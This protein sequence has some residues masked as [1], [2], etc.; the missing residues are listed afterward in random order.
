MC[1]TVL[2][3]QIL[4][5]IFFYAEHRYTKQTFFLLLSNGIFYSLFIQID[6]VCTCVCL[7]VSACNKTFIIPN[8]SAKNKERNVRKWK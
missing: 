5:W 2:K 6:R 8:F 1:I 4:C 7:S 3:I